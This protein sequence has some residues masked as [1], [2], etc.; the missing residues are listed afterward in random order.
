[1]FRQIDGYEYE[2]S[3]HGEVR[4]RKT[5][6]ILKPKNCIGYHQVNLYKDGRKTYYVHRLVATAFLENPDNLPDVDHKI[7]IRNDNRLENLHWVNASQNHQNIPMP[8]TNTSGVKGVYRHRNKWKATL[9]LD[10]IHI[11][12]GVYDTIEEARDARVAK[13]TEVFSNAHDTEK[14][15]PR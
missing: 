8:K 9:M 15:S 14:E 2:V 3:D 5:M 4:N 11:H 10:G 13:V 1:M 12:I 7:G 6:K